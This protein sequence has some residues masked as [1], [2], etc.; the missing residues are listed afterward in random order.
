MPLPTRRN[1]PVGLSKSVGR[2]A[3]SCFE[4]NV[5]GGT[6]QHPVQR[7]L[8]ATPVPLQRLRSGG[9]WPPV[10]A[11][12][13]FPFCARDVLTFEVVANGR[14]PR[15]L[16]GKATSRRTMPT[17]PPDPAPLCAAQARPT[18]RSG[19]KP[20][21][22]SDAPPFPPCRRRETTFRRPFRCRI[23]SVPHPKR[24]P[25]LAATPCGVSAAG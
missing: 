4:W 18:R 15:T 3:G 2:G 5:Y 23:T 9:C 17:H 25:R 16:P 11:M 22:R 24:R 14:A 19:M 12:R 8:P 6:F 7:F 10:S 13:F 20:R 21:S 1:P